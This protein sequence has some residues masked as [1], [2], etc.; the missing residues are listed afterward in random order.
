MFAGEPQQVALTPVG[1]CVATTLV[2]SVGGQLSVA[3]IAK[4]T[5]VLSRGA[6]ARPLP[7]DPLCFHD[8]FTDGD[9]HK[10]LIAATDLVPYRPRA[11]VLL[12]A[13]AHVPLNLPPSHS[14]FPVRLVVARD[15][16]TLLDKR[17]TVVAHSSA[18][19]DHPLGGFRLVPL[20]YELAGKSDANP[21][22]AGLPSLRDAAGKPRPV[23]VGPISP[24][25]PARRLSLAGMTPT[26][27]AGI[28][29]L[30]NNFPWHF[31]QA[32]PEDQRVEYLR[33][34]EWIRLEGM[35]RDL[36]PWQTRLPGVR[37]LARVELRSQ[38][39]TTVRDLLL[40]LDTLLI[41]ADRGTVSVVGRASF[42]VTDASVLPQLRVFA[43]VEVTGSPLA[44]PAGAPESRGRAARATQ[45]T[46]TAGP[47]SSKKQ[48]KTL[49]TLSPPGDE[50]A[51]ASTPFKSR[52][53]RVK[54]DTLVGAIEPPVPSTP[55]ARADSPPR[56]R[57]PKKPVTMALDRSELERAAAA[58]RAGDGLP[59]AHGP[60]PVS[61]P[62]PAPPL[63]PPPPPAH[64]E[65]LPAPSEPAPVTLAF[66]TQ[67]PAA[68]LAPPPEIV[69]IAGPPPTLGQAFLAA[70]QR[71]QERRGAGRVT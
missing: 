44:W 27:K 58:A 18:G 30:P 29:E 47:P 24:S 23:G 10:S 7:P 66:A 38:R 22:G 12:T 49:V 68:A 51:P 17:L 53:G 56:S 57:R 21:V 33:G 62:T 3:V 19:S 46:A 8:V 45:P 2:F 5:F 63:P 43:G 61:R 15:Q 48:R 34:D 41:D 67:P 69:V 60:L 40:S 20:S 54:I 14:L 37:G 50:A 11:D 39:A 28:V 26:A 25:W 42:P 64:F 1:P 9:A 70:W 6:A 16:R 4:A 55:F 35:S 13:H 65:P 31:F 36:E 32:A 71:A 59:F 52:R